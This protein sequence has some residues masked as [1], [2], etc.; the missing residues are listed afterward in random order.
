M[1][2]D[3]L[4]GEVREGDAAPAAL[5]TWAVACYRRPLTAGVLLAARITARTTGLAPKV[6]DLVPMVVLL[7]GLYFVQQR[8][9]AARASISPTMSA[10]QQK[11]MQYLPVFFAGDVTGNGTLDIVIAESEYV[12]G[13]MAWFENRLAEGEGLVEHRMEA[14][15]LRF[16][17][18][19]SLQAWV[20]GD[21][22]LHRRQIVGVDELEP[23]V[24]AHGD[25]GR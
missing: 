18:A 19:H 17:F 12:D 9:V 22:L 8:M 14:G 24:S 23:C 15:S 6:V 13:L 21:G 10:G 5:L 11:L 3:G 7:G 16:N 4:P 2:I 25:I 1:I 20:D